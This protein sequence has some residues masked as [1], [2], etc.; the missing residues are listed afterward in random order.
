LQ[1]CAGGG[2]RQQVEGV[3][4]IAG[5]QVHRVFG[6]GAQAGADALGVFVGAGGLVVGFGVVGGVF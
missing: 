6:G 2:D 4:I 1:R 3:V 5:G